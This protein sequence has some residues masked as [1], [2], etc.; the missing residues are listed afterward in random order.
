MKFIFVSF[1][2]TLLFIGCQQ[3]IDNI[4]QINELNITKSKSLVQKVLS[5]DNC[6]QII[7]NSYIKICYS[8]RYKAAKAVVYTL[9]GDLVDAVNIKER[10]R[11]YE[12]KSIPTEYRATY[13][14]YKNSGYDRGHLAPDAAFDYSKESL[15]AVYTLANIVPQ[16]PDVNQH[17]WVK[18]EE[19]ARKEA[20]IYGKIEVINIVKYGNNPKRI[21]ENKIAVAEGF[22]KIMYNKAEDYKEC[23]YYKNENNTSRALYN[24]LIDCNL[25][26]Y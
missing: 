26:T 17:T 18:A 13:Y 23:F 7:D 1:L 19:H 4:E 15:H 10:D 9:D 6:D 8:Y 22:Y 24:H 11:F 25:V 2:I 21:G 3:N 20:K 5:K 12:E 14:D 16:I